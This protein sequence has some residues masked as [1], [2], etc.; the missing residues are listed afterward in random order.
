MLAGVAGAVVGM[1]LLARAS[2]MLLAVVVAGI[3][4][5]QANG[6]IALPAPDIT[7]SAAGQLR[8]VQQRSVVALTCR[9]ALLGAADAEDP[10]VVRY[11]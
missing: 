5:L 7:T 11:C 6:V 1:W 8:G 4:G 9:Q 3:G 10:L 2:P